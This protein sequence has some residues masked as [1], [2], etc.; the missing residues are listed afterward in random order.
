MDQGV[1]QRWGITADEFNAA[2]R[3]NTTDAA[4]LTWLQSRVSD[5]VRQEVNRWL[6]EEKAANMDRQDAEEGVVTAR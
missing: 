1:F 5:T 3:T 4:I 2:I 6:R